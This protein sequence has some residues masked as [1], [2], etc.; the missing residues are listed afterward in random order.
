M[1]TYNYFLWGWV[2]EIATKSF[3]DESCLILGNL[4]NAIVLKAFSTWMG[5]AKILH[6]LD[7][8]LTFMTHSRSL[9]NSLDINV[10]HRQQSNV[11]KL[12]KAQAN[13]KKL[14]WL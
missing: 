14:V 8:S 12:T 1:Q 2:K 3:K 4:I 7:F 9:G 10:S 6:Y 11:E 5:F 13:S